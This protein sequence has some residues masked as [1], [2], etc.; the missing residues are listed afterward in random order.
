MAPTAGDDARAAAPT[1][2]DGDDEDYMNMVIE[3]PS[4]KETSL[5]KMQREKREVCCSPRLLSASVDTH[6]Q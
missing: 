6:P 1:A 5:Q 3:E 2:D 4:K